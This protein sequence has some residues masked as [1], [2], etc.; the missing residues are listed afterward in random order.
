LEVRQL[1]EIR[2][3]GRRRAAEQVALERTKFLG[4]GRLLRRLL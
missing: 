1:V 4:E 2:Q 3:L